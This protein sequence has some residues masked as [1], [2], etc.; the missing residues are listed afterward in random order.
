MKNFVVKEFCLE[1]GFVVNKSILCILY[2]GRY[3]VPELVNIFIFITIIQSRL[4]LNYKVQQLF[5]FK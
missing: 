1:P 5:G 4:C 2:M 3:K